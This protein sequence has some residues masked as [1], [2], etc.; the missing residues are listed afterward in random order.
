M[1]HPI[2]IDCRNMFDNTN[3]DMIYLGIGKPN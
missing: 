2:V 3:I 1:K